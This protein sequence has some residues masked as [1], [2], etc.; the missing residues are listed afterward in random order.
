M[1]LNKIAIKGTTQQHLPLEDVKNDLVILK[2]G[3]CVMVLE[4]S[5]VN[6]DLL[7][8]RE[9]EAMVYAY[10]ALLNSLTF[11]IQVVI[12]ST[13]KDVSTYVNR[14]KDQEKKID[15]PMLQK[16]IVSYRQF[17]E[18]VVRK[19]NVLAKSFYLVIP[20]FST[21]LG[22][23]SAA[24]SS[25]FPI[26]GKSK[27]E[28]KLPLPKEEIIQK[29]QATLEPKKEHLIRLFGRLGLTIKQVNSKNLIKLF[30]QIYN[31]ESILSER[32]EALSQQGP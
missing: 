3:S 17:V 31:Q 16:Q 10:A 20:F 19:N 11:P 32:P 15:N 26:P 18:D 12:R 9:Q 5:S 8:E 14:L 23:A 27:K 7:S 29:A 2:D 22:L 21:E 30:Y 6:F 25:P 4:T 24:G 13:L 28:S 1:D